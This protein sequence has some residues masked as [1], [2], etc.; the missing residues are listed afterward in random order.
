MSSHVFKHM[1]KQQSD[2]VYADPECALVPTVET[3]VVY[4]HV[5]KS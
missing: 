2:G 4:A 5:A 1:L 3:H